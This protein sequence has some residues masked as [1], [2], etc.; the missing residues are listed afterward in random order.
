VHFDLISLPNDLEEMNRLAYEFADAVGL[1]FDPLSN[2]DFFR[3]L[4]H[5]CARRWGLVIELLIEAF[6]IATLESTSVCSID[7][8]VAAFATRFRLPGGFSPFTAPD[9]EECFDPSKMLDLLD[10]KD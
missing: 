7:H 9:Y 5:A 2:V 3:R 4:N 10:R 6:T 8:F 1:C